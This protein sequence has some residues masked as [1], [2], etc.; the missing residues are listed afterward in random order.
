MNYRIE[1]DSLGRVEIPEKCLWGIHT[2]RALDNFRLC[3]CR[4]SPS[5]IKAMALVKKACCLA[6][7][8]TGYL[9]ENK[10]SAIMKA[11]DE[12]IEGKHADQFPLDPLQGGAGTSTN[13]NMNEVISNRALEIAGREPGDYS[14]IHPIR[15][16]NMHQSTNDVYPTAVKIAVIQSLRELSRRIESLQAA[17]QKKEKE[18]AHIVK[19]GRTEMQEAVPMTLGAEFSAFAEAIA[20]DRWRVFKCE[21]RIRS[22]NLG[23]TAVGTG[24]TAPRSYI[25]LVIEKLRDLTGFGLCRGENVVDQTA[26]SDSFIEVTGI[27]RAHA[28][29]VI[30]ICNDLRMLNM[31]GEVRLKAV[32]TGSSVMPG[33]VNPVILESAI[34][35]CL[36]AEADCRLA[37]EAS[38]RSS[39]QINEFMPLLAL[40]VLEALGIFVN[41]NDMLA[42]HVACLEAD[43][44]TCQEYVENS[45]FI[46]TAFVPLLGYEKCERLLAEFFSGSSA[47]PDIKKFLK[48]KL[49]E[50]TV[51]KT[52]S[53][54]NLM[55]LGYR[56]HEKNT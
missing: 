2:Q 25:F 50:E 38:S 46:M 48:E 9:Q 47:Q 19:I 42:E 53:P 33:K 6:N 45:P 15:D 12:I 51:K 17:F 34:Q 11:C 39:F 52:L 7:L 1:S 56:E 22:V 8:E 43:E 44:S 14:M 21:E 5:L 4:Q 24:L 32:Q 55:S 27:L 10:A 40:G 16:V 29:N 3:P 23:G 31:L 20:R 13:M 36:K 35:S 28:S 26:N 30:K 49:G 37:F 18:F 54:Q 41:V